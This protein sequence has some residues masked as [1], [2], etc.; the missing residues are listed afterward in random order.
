MLEPILE[1]RNK[2]QQGHFDF[3]ARLRR[4]DGIYRHVYVRITSFQHEDILYHFI[5]MTDITEL[6]SKDAALFESEQRF[7]MMA[8]NIQD[9]LMIIEN[10]RLVYSNGRLTEI[11]GYSMEELCTMNTRDLITP[12]EL[13]KMTGILKKSI[14]CKEPPAAFQSWILCKDGEK[15]YIFGH[16]K[17]VRHQE[18]VSTYI[19]MTDVT[20]FALREKELLDQI[21]KLEKRK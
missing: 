10:E 19:T 14:T 17:S 7:R 12:E 20:A 18:T 6:V 21:S 11:S 2:P 8:E 9:G 3:R 15:R 5:I 4:K 13:Q 16:I 1:L